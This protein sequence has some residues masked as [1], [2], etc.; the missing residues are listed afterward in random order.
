MRLHGPDG[1]QGTIFLSAMI[2]ALLMAI[3]GG[4]IY[5]LSSQDMH[6]VAQLKKSLQAQQ[7]AEAGLSEALNTLKDDWNQKD[8]AGAFPETDLGA[9]SYD[10][11]IVQSS[12]R[13][14][15]S[16]VGAVDG[17]T[18]TATAEVSG[19]SSSSVLDYAIAAGGNAVI[20]SGTGQSPGSI[21]GDIYSGGNAVLDGPSSGG[22]LAITG[23]VDAG[24]SIDSSSSVTISGA[25]TPDHEEVAF[26]TVDMAYYQNI[27]T[28]NGNY[29][30]GNRTYNN[31]SPI[32]SDPAGGVIYVS[33][34]ITIQGTQSTTAC[35]V[36]GGNITIN[37]SGSAYPCV[38]I[39]APDSMPAVVT[40]GNFTYSST[41]N[42]GAYLTI[43]G[44]SY[45]GGNF[46]FTSGNHDNL[47]LAGSLLAQGNIVISP[48]SYN[49]ISVSY[50][51]ETLNGFSSSSGSDEMEIL[52]YN[53]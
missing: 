9:G 18:R 14:L 46:T 29:T 19:P 35:L 1:K 45:S 27:A 44:V 39:N 10:A 50:G 38:T 32:P 21:V 41:G 7:L 11:D 33:G 20:D 23:G 22:V 15:I 24:G 37:K 17:T 4:S 12:G 8:S 3:V 49:Q 36:A 47:T 43:N 34:N 2:S 28:V 6:Y 42:G 5:R 13:V 26:P 31:T 25:S 16:S 53:R 52:S 48:T 40:Q 30:D 51:S